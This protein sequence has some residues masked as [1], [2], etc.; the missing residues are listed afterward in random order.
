M[1]YISVTGVQTCALPI[2]EDVGYATEDFWPGAMKSNMWKGKTYGI[3]TNNETMARSE[4][5]RVGKDGIYQCDWSSDV[6]S[7][8]L[9]RRR[10]R[11]GGFLARR[12]EVQHVEGQDV[13]D[14]DQQ[15]DHG[16]IGRASCRERWYISV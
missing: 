3:P 1:V 12:H 10:L 16:E 14:P 13:R 9:R 2:S 11:D 15:R 8:D 4:E 5:R 6:C 7:S